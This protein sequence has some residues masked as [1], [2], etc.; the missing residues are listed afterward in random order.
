[1]KKPKIFIQ[2]CGH[3]SN[4]LLVICGATKKE[5]F[6]FLKKKKIIY[7]KSKWVLENFDEWN[8]LVPKTKL[9]LFCW[10]TE[11]DT[12]VLFLGKFSDDWVYLETLMHELHHA[13]L[14]IAKQKG[15]LEE[16][17]N[18]AYLFE[19]LFRSIRRKISGVDPAN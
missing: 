14:H 17:E 8:G 13:T 12:T 2:D 4:Q 19:F 1:M 15:F 3:Y 9:G 10:D 6:T 5:T 18:Q 16:M 11:I 7:A